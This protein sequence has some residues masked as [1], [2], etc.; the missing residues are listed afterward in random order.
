ML[1]EFESVSLLLRSTK[2]LTR[3]HARENYGPTRSGKTQD[4]TADRYTDQW[5]LHHPPIS[6]FS[7]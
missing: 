7:A 5:H 2:T 3:L 6:S 4:S 1:L